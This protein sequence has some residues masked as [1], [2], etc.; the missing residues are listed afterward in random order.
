MFIT[1]DYKELKVKRLNKFY[2]NILITTI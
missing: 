2:N 1:S